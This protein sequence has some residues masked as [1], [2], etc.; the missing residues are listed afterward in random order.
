VPPEVAL[1]KVPPQLAKQL[2]LDVK[3]SSL[4]KPFESFP[5]AIGPSDRLR[6]EARAATAIKGS[7]VPALERLPQFLT[8]PY[9]PGC[10]KDIAA[11]KFPDGA[12]YYQALI[13][14][15][16][17]TDLSAEAIHEIGTKEVKR[18]RGEMGGVIKETG[19]SGSFPEFLTL[20]RTDPRFAQMEPDQVLPAFRDIAKRVDPELPKLVA[21]LPRTPYGIREMLPQQRPQI[22]VLDHPSGI[23]FD[24]DLV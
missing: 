7:I 9:V 4:Y 16:T 2:A 8:E 22:C 13:K 15:Y 10:R 5:E 17:T 21:E 12:A 19:F 3:K 14:F 20:L 1:R 11:T 24:G 18:I 6:L 23:C